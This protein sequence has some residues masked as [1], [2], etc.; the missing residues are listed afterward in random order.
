MAVTPEGQAAEPPKISGLTKKATG[1]MNNYSSANKGGGSPGNSGKS[2]GSGGSK[3]ADSME[4]VEKEA[5][6]YH[7]VD[8]QLDLSDKD[9]DN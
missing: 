2:G 7:D 8:V 1:S 9:L 5:D 3:K 6:R 4:P